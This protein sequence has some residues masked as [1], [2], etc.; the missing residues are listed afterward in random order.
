VPVTSGY[1]SPSEVTK[2]LKSDN[3]LIR[4]CIQNTEGSFNQLTI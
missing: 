2:L 4:A 1:A 3:T